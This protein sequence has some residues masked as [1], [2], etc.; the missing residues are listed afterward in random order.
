MAA[1][2]NAKLLKRELTPEEHIQLIESCLEKDD[3]TGASWAA[4]QF[5]DVPEKLRARIVAGLMQS[6][7]ANSTEEAEYLL[8]PDSLLD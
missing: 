7:D 3:L 5:K 6:G 2:Q 4:C 8:S 1:H